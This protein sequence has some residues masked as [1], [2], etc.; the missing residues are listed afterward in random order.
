MKR[1]IF[2]AV[3]SLIAALAAYSQDNYDVIYLNNGSV[4]QGSITNLK[5][6]QSV[7]TR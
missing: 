2:A 1:F 3:L 5:E 6:N 4:I 7:P